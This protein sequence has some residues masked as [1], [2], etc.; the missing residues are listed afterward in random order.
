[1]ANVCK[2]CGN[3]LPSRAKFCAKCG[4]PTGAVESAPPTPDAWD[5]P[6]CGH[7]NSKGIFCAK[8]GAKKPSGITTS[9]EEIAAPTQIEGETA[10]TTPSPLPE[11]PV[12]APPAMKPQPSDMP[13]AFRLWDITWVQV[14]R[15]G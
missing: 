8:C 12:T 1:M 14:L 13:D 6:A 2:H 9:P 7:E 10:P 15:T 11:M 3:E 5:C 4:T